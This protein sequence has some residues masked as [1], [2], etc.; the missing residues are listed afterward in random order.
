M[1]CMRFSTR[2]AC[3]AVVGALAAL[4]GPA[5]AAI[6]Q[7]TALPAGKFVSTPSISQNGGFLAFGTNGNVAGLNASGIPNIFVYD[8]ASG[9][10]AR[11]TTDGGSDP[12]ISGNGRFVAFSSSADYVGRNADGSDEI[13][14]YD[15]IRKRFVQWT[16]DVNG[17]GASELP[18]I[19]GDGRKIA[20][21]TTSNTRRRNPD[22]SP[23]VYV[24]IRGGNLALS[25]DP[26]GDGESHNVAIS[27]DGS[28]AAFETTSD[29][30]GRNG[31]FSQELMV[32]DLKRRELSQ[33]T[34]DPDGNGSSGTAA[35][36]GDG[37]FIVFIS[38]SNVAGLNPDGADAV[39]LLNRLRRDYA[40]LT[41]SLDGV[42]DGDTPSINDD[43]RWI[44][45]VTGFN[46]T[47]GNPDSNREI[48]LYDR[49][50][51]TFTQLTSSTGCFNSTP[52]ISGDGSRVAFLS[53]CNYAGT[54]GDRSTE[55]FLVDNPA[56][57]LAV[58]SEGPVALV[59]TD[60]SGGIIS[61]LSNTIP[62][63][64][65]TQGDF[66]GDGQPEDRVR[67]PLAPE[68]TYNIHV[69]PDTGAAL[70]DPLT[71]SVSLSNLTIP[72]PVATV[73]DATGGD[74]TFGNQTFKRPQSRMTPLG[75]IG[76]LVVLTTTLPHVPADGGSV[77]I[78]FSDGIDELAFD[79]GRLE[80]FTRRGASRIFSGTAGGFVV[81]CRVIKRA[82]GTTGIR[83]AARH[84]DLSMFAGTT[85]VSMTMVVQV[86][87]DADMYN[88]RF[89]RGLSGRLLLR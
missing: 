89:K 77:R 52:K 26:N 75:G 34:N 72:M 80:N 54:N 64:S 30:K 17:D 84:G 61:P 42:F 41:T 32:Y 19:D 43:G 23:E 48:L 74:F 82:N 15:R 40:V 76:S 62:Y 65:Y 50:H 29:L 12:T 2:G 16:R 38:S 24:S 3:L 53:N 9:Q 70:T 20:F 10:F 21:E 11:I 81:N 35:V 36:S 39:Y 51:K 78:R 66:D 55:V 86:G 63:A 79:L 14:R 58:D 22:F 57:N 83:F 6:V 46:V 13:F 69:V 71:L 47:G 37:R 59:V 67:I 33:V 49:S 8:L 31:D 60:P 27:A 56:L 5:A 44:T 85:D 25:H 73:A 88:W 87:A 1:V 28:V 7:V 45:F 18:I 4:V 68:G